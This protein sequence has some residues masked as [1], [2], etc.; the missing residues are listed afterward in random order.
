[1]YVCVLS[2]HFIPYHLP[3]SLP[4]SPLSVWLYNLQ[5]VLGGFHL[6]MVQPGYV[7]L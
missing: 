6:D 3:L 4:P 1:M 5:L 7:S 2:V